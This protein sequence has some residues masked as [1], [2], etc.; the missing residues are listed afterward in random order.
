MAPKS[1]TVENNTD[2]KSVTSE[3]GLASSYS[4]EV[5]GLLGLATLIYATL[6]LF[7]IS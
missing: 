2:S 5:I 3:S 7:F 6:A 4:V 1:K